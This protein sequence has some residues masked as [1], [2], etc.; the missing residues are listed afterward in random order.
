[1]ALLLVLLSG[2]L[3]YLFILT[4]TLS[5]TSTCRFNFLGLILALSAHTQS[6]WGWLQKLKSIALSGTEYLIAVMVAFPLS[7][8]ATL[9]RGP[10]SINA[11][12]FSFSLNYSYTVLALFSGS[13]LGCRGQNRPWLYL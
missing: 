11:G 3:P 10:F 12:V 2:L 4:F 8:V 6:G 13:A 1:M 9:F 7:V 5:L